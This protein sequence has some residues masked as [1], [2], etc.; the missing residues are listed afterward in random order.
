MLPFL[1]RCARPADF[2]ACALLADCL[3][4]ELRRLDPDEVYGEVLKS[5]V[6][7]GNIVV[8]VNVDDV[9]DEGADYTEVYDA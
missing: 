9:H 2:P 3:A 5:V 4:E 1:P 7:S 6:A 8:D